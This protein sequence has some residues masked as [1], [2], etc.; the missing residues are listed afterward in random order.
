M[1]MEF[2]DLNNKNVSLR[3]TLCAENK[4][5]VFEGE[6]KQVSRTIKSELPKHYHTDWR[7]DTNKYF[8]Y[9]LGRKEGKKDYRSS[10]YYLRHE[11]AVSD[12]IK[13][14]KSNKITNNKTK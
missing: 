5:I 1:I 8:W 14:Y 7:E 9:Y 6:M 11:D 13:H 4:E 12:A 2:S 3:A 10:K